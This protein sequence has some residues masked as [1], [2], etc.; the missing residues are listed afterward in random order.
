MTPNLSVAIVDKVSPATTVYV[1]LLPSEHG[2][3]VVGSV[4]SGVVV[5]GMQAESGIAITSPTRIRS[6]LVI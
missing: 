4:G 5:P 2:I 3:G 1:V 6:A